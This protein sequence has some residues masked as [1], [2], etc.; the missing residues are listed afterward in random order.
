M[1]TIAELTYTGKFTGLTITRHYLVPEENEKLEQKCEE[2]RQRNITFELQIKN[3][4]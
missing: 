3:I 1:K 2:L 4:I